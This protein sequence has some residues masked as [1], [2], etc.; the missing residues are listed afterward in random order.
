MKW[1]EPMKRVF[2]TLCMKFAL[3]NIM[4]KPEQFSVFFK[5]HNEKLKNIF[6]VS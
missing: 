3:Y 1:P 4:S 5:E 6:L 2:F